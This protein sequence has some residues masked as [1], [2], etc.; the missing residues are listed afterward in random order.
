M[1]LSERESTVWFESASTLDERTWIK[2]GIVEGLACS[3]AE[4][5]QYAEAAAAFRRFSSFMLR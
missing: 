1:A 4:S 2:A 3:L 5:Q